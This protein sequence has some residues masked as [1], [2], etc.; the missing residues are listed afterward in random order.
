M[1]RIKN[2][3]IYCITFIVASFFINC[4][5]ELKQAPVLLF[6]GTGT[7]PNDVEAIKDILSSNHTDFVLVNSDWLN[8]LDTSLLR[9]Y[10]LLIV[11][12]GDFIAMG[13]SLTKRTVN[14][15]Q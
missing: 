5:S 14:N 9:R 7:S 13:K 11:P 12:G 2:K 15:V 10:K 1:A 6:N 3:L 8:G 4:K